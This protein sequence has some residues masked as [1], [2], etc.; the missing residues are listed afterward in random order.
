MNRERTA[1]GGLLN[2]I[3]AWLRALNRRRLARRRLAKERARERAWF[4]AND[5]ASPTVAPALQRRLGNL[6]DRPLLTIV[7]QPGADTGRAPNWPWGTA[8]PL[9]PEWELLLAD[10]APVSHGNHGSVR[11]IPEASRLDPV[12]RFTCLLGAAKGSHIVIVPEDGVLASHA[13]LLFAEAINRFPSAKVFYAD[14]DCIDAERRH[15]SPHLRC[16]WNLEL[17]RSH[18]YLNGPLVVGRDVLA[19]WSG[20]G[21]DAPESLWWSMVLRATELQAACDIVHVPHVLWHRSAPMPRSTEPPRSL[22]PATDADVTVVQRHLDRCTVAAT[23]MPGPQGG[24]HVRYLVPQP[25]PLV[26]LLIPTRNGL[27]LLR[28]CIQSILDKTD[29]RPYEIIVIDNGSDEPMTLSYLQQLSADPRIQ[30]IRDDRPFNFS[31]LN[32]AAVRACRGTVLGLINN[33]IEVIDP[34]WLSEMVGLALRDDV[35]AVG[36]RLWFSDGTLQHAGVILGLG[37]VAGHPYHKKAASE[38][39]HFFRARLTQ[40]F[41]AVTA[42]CLVLRREVFEEVDGLDEENLAVDYNDID[43]CLRIRRAGHRVIWTPHA[44]LFHHE[45][46]TRGLNRSPESARRYEAEREFMLRTWGASLEN[47]RAYNPNLALRGRDFSISPTPRVSLITPWFAPMAQ[48]GDR[49]DGSMP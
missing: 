43:F 7:A 41:S 26:S 44:N 32:N 45:S 4:A 35:G 48:V 29:Y 5:P 38:L 27:S 20:V 9:Y 14:D 13:L 1:Q 24:V 15:H 11:V 31:A 47:D 18:N 42:A 6:V 2:R 23:A 30:V 19:C 39:G 25:A 17:L 33:D 21:A 46:A 8:A 28:Q 12:A 37:G 10:E 3:G 49:A 34:H 40:E 22:A 36:A 16:D